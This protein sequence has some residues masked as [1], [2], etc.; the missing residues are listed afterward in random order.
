MAYNDILRL[1][2]YYQFAAVQMVNVMHFVSQDVTGVDTPA[3]LA[4]DFGVNLL[5]SM[6]ARTANTV[7][8][9][10]V[11]VQKI[12]PFAGGP[13]VYTYP[14]STFGS[15]AGS[16]ASATLCEVVTIYSERGG[17]RGRGRVYLPTSEQSSSSASNGSWT[18]TQATRTAG[19]VTAMTSRYITATPTPRWYLGVWSRASGPLA[20]PWTTSQFAR[21]TGLVAR[22]TI[23]TQRR[24]Q[25]GVGR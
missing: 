20:P 3:D 1:R 19:F 10:Y 18:A 8:F 15:V 24:R 23:R 14:A 2:V 9:Q 21:A 16:V 11:E 13:A 12:V 5:A 17:R 4:S 22:A 7:V 6:R 25:L